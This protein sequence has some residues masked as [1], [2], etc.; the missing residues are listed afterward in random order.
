MSKG[1][2]KKALIKGVGDKSSSERWKEP[3]TS[4]KENG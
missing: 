4:G 1:N 2:D 3:D